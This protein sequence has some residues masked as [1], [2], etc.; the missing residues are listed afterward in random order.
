MMISKLPPRPVLP[1][2]WSISQR[3]AHDA[4]TESLSRVADEFGSALDQAQRRGD[5]LQIELRLLRDEVLEQ[6]GRHRALGT[7]VGLD[8]AAAIVQ[9]QIIGVVLFARQRDAFIRE[10]ALQRLAVLRLIVDEHAVEVEQNRLGHNV[11][12]SHATTAGQHDVRACSLNTNPRCD[13]P[14]A[15]ASVLRAAPT[16]STTCW[17]ACGGANIQSDPPATPRYGVLS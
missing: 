8:K 16:R 2:T 12:L 5:K 9:A 7:T 6:L 11:S 17:H 14:G 4:Q 1:R 3:T 15:M 10:H 13:N